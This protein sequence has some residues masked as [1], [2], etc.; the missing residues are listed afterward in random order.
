[1]EIY[2]PRFWGFVTDDGNGQY[3]TE[4]EWNNERNSGKNISAEAN[5]R[6]QIPLTDEESYA[7]K[8]RSKLDSYNR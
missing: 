6:M 1:M 4:S 7:S 5:T 8:R 3:S 2:Y